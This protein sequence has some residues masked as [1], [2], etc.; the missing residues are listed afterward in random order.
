MRALKPGLL[1][2]AGLALISI[3]PAD[4]FQIM[5]WENYHRFRRVQPSVGP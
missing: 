4:D 2:M 3:I 1:I 5:Y